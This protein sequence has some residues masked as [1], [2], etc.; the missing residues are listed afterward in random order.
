[1]IEW[2][3]ECLIGSQVHLQSMKSK[4]IL[5]ARRNH[6]KRDGD[7]VPPKDVVLF[8]LKPDSEFIEP[9]ETLQIFNQS[10]HRDAQ[11]PVEIVL[12]VKNVADA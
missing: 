4:R 3:E 1:L 10:A 12:H 6:I 9:G 7:L 5:G 2:G 11:R 8:S